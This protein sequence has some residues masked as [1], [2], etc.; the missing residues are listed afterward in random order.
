MLER[1]LK[2]VRDI[3]QT[4]DLEEKPLTLANQFCQL[5]QQVAELESQF[6][7]V[8]KLSREKDALIAKL[9]SVAII[10]DNM[11]LDGVVYYL[12]KDGDILDGPFCTHCFR[13]DQETVRVVP[14]A[15]PKSTSGDP[16]EW[17]QCVKCQKPFRSQRVSAYLNTSRTAPGAT[18]VEKRSKPVRKA[19]AKKKARRSTRAAKAK[20]R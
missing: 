13:K 14:A 1:I 6:G 19:P 3:K 15:K 7:E 8:Q 10:K 17:A 20:S 9:Q 12:R 16:A 2:G 18:G 5:K 4:F 11:I